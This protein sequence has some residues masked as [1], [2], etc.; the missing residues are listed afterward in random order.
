MNLDTMG[1]LYATDDLRIIEMKKV[2]APIQ[3][4]QDYPVTK[5]RQPLSLTHVKP[6]IIFC[7]ELM[8]DYW[9]LLGR[10]RFTTPKQRVN[11]P[12]I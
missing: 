5:P 4:H 1:N 6:S 11:M 10:A 12:A 3:L 8:I 9:S 7:I 2:A